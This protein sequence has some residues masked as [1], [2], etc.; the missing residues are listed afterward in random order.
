MNG[1]HGVKRPRAN[2]FRMVQ[3]GLLDAKAV[4]DRRRGMGHKNIAVELPALNSTFRQQRSRLAGRISIRAAELDEADHLSDRTTKLV[5]LRKQ[6]SSPEAA[7]AALERQRNHA[8]RR[9]LRARAPRRSR[10]P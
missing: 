2:P 4:D 8:L 7:A 9:R 5:G 10:G 3:L 6:A 1:V